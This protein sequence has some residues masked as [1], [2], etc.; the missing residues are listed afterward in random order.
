MNATTS[1]TMLRELG[2]VRHPAEIEK[3]GG[4]C[5]LALGDCPAKTEG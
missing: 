5:L 2:K 1:R 3:A 4:M